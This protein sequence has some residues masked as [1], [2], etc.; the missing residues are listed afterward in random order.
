MNKVSSTYAN[1]VEVPVPIKMDEKVVIQASVE[2][3]NTFLT[4]I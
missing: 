3:V 4:H 2:K 1:I